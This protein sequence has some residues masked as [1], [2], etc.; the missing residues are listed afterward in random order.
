MTH[1]EGTNTGDL[2]K[3]NE[4]QETNRVALASAVKWPLIYTAAILVFIWVAFSIAPPD[5]GWRFGMRF[6]LFF[7]IATIA[8]GLF[9]SYLKV[10]PMPQLRSQWKVSLS[11]AAAF[12]LP[13]TALVALGTALPQ[14]DIPAATEEAKPASAEAR[15][16]ALFYDPVVGCY[17][18]HVVKGSGGTRGPDLSRIGE[19]AETRQPDVSVEEYLR[20]SIT[21]PV[22]F[23]APGYPAIM[24]L[25]LGDRLSSAQIDDLV[26]YLMSLR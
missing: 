22:A 15:G 17:L 21:D 3:L 25:N 13:V 16:K 8:G 6:K 9:F 14:F 4:G 11:I 20:E 24:P 18:C 12:L 23:T 19:V 2:R 1:D 26:A 7:S 10:G 5:S